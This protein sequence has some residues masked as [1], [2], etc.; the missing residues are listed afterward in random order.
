MEKTIELLVNNSNSIWY[1]MGCWMCLSFFSRYA[2]LNAFLFLQGMILLVW[3]L[4]TYV[5]LNYEKGKPAFWI[6]LAWVSLHL[7][8]VLWANWHQVALKLSLIQLVDAILW[9]SLDAVYSVHSIKTHF[10]YT[11]SLNEVRNR[12]KEGRR[13]K[14][15]WNYS[16]QNPFFWIWLRCT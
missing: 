8:D 5:T 16:S 9:F 15:P 10:T 4:N 7:S 1:Q 3:N 14:E 13:V 12:I 6:N 2:T 11:W